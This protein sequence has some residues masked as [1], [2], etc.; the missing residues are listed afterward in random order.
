MSVRR[1]QSIFVHLAVLAAFLFALAVAAGC[2]GDDDA[3]AGSDALGTS[4]LSKKQYVKQA[5]QRC[6]QERLD[7]LNRFVASSKKEGNPS[8]AFEVA[9][10]PILAPSLERQA[11]AIRTLGAPEGDEE[12]IEALLAEM[13]RVS[14]ALA[15]DPVSDFRDYGARL[16]PAAVLAREYGF[17]Q[18]A[19]PGLV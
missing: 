9:S 10:R 17:S 11:D 14:T 6:R 3:D 16:Q 19:S 13:E 15:E 5:D 18:C 7:A 1:R 12:Q 8:R 4:S 2:G